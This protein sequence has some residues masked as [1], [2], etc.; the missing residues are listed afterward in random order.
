MKTHINSMDRTVLLSKVQ[1][2]RLLTVSERQY[3]TENMP[4]MNDGQCEKLAKILAEAEGLSWDAEMQN[5]LSIAT[6]AT[7]ALAA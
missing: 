7:A 3:W 2:S 4:N 1:T 6:K 5:Y